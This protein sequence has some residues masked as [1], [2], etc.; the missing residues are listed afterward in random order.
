M[1]K[2]PIVLALVS[3]MIVCLAYFLN[4]KCNDEEI[5]KSTMVKLSVIAAGVSLLT[6]YFIN[7]G[8]SFSLPNQDVLTGDPGF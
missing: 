7:S 3:A 2:N 8:E 1:I 6:Y 4:N 5:N